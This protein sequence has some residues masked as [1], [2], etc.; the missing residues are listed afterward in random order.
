M[1]SLAVDIGR[2]TMAGSDVK[3][4]SGTFKLD[5]EGLTFDKVRIADLAD[6]AFSLNGRMC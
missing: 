2:A 3:G 5:P 4:V 1:I 6:A